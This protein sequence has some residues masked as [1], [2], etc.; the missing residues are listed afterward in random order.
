[1]AGT[2]LIHI[3]MPKTGTTAL[4]NFMLNNNDKL[5][6]YGWCYPILSGNSNMDDLERWELKT[7]GNGYKMYDALIES[8]N[9]SEWD[10]GMNILLKF[11]KN[12]NVILST[13][14]IY[15]HGTEEF[16][17]NVKNSHGNI[18]V[19][20]YLRRQ[21]RVIESRYN[22]Y[23]KSGVECERFQKFLDSE[24]IPDGLLDFLL[25][26]DSISRVIGKEN[27][28]VR[29]YEKQQLIGNDIITDFLSVLGVPLSSKD[30]EWKKSERIND[31]LEGNYLEI[32]RLMNSVRSVDGILESVNRAWSWSDWY[33]ANDI[34]NVCMKF[35]SALTQNGEKRGFFSLDERKNFLEKFAAGNEQVARKYLYREDGILF[36][37]KQMEYP[38]YEIGQS[39]SFEADMIRVFTAMLYIQDQRMR[40]LLAEK[41][42]ECKQECNGLKMKIQEL[43]RKLLIDDVFIKRKGRALLL[44]GAG[45]NCEKL[46]GMA[47]NIS[48]VS[49]VDNDLKKRGTDIVGIQIKNVKDIADWRKYFIIV[50]C[51]ESDAIEEQ[52]CSL[53]VRK[54]EDYI[55][56]REYGIL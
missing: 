32:N 21:D 11:L 55:L 8:H 30:L 43:G 1:M 23:I 40:D 3:G 22:Q 48:G 2:L 24:Y 50:T 15:E 31:S 12:R 54:G 20:V 18:K 9:V 5:E 41:S 17:E 45:R 37:D 16:I 46:L 27:L 13:E 34:R 25:K 7:V 39:S 44:F 36:Y 10:K 4:Q 28:I 56:M 33:V 52:L 49:I 6:K 47:E 35:S 19:V 51:S 29:V 26:L 38:M 42:S 14:Y 53:G